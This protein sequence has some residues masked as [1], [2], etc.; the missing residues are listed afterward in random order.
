[1]VGRRIKVTSQDIDSILSLREKGLSYK[2]IGEKL[3]LPPSTVRYYC[4]YD[5][6]KEFRK[7]HRLKIPQEKRREYIREYMRKRY[8]KDRDFRRRLRELQKEYWDRIKERNSKVKAK[9]V[10]CPYCGSEWY[11]KDGTVP[12][13]CRKC[14]RLLVRYEILD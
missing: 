11:T 5:K 6:E 1:M 3:G 14:R 12:G 7:R 2:K 13:F 9:R 8:S 10:R 4:N